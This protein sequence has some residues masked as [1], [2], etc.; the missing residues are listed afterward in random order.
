MTSKSP[1]FRVL[2]GA[3][4]RAPPSSGKQWLDFVLAVPDLEQPQ[5]WLPLHRWAHSK[6]TI[7]LRGAHSTVL[8]CL[9]AAEPA[10]G[11]QVAAGKSSQRR[12]LCVFQELCQSTLTEMESQKQ[13][14]RPLTCEKSKPVPLK[15]F[16]PRLVKVWVL[17]ASP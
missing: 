10:R 12:G 17:A 8:S 1:P 4:T 5:P 16:T 9:D 14:C 7:L 6:G 3:S 13:L 15:L 11:A 2:S